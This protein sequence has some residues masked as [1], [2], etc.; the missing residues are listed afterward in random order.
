MA[1]FSLSSIRHASVY[2]PSSR[3]DPSPGALMHAIRLL[4]YMYTAVYTSMRCAACHIRVNASR[5]VRDCDRTKLSHYRV[6]PSVLSRAVFTLFKTSL[7]TAPR[8]VLSIS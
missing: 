8:P 1:H 4:S 6:F 2:V 7:H 3:V 5:D